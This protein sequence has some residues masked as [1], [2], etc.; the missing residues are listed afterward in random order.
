MSGFWQFANNDGSGITRI[1]KKQNPSLEELLDEKETVGQLLASNAKLIQYFRRPEILDKLVEYVVSGDNYRRNADTVAPD[2]NEKEDTQ[3]QSTSKSQKLKESSAEPKADNEDRNESDSD[4]SSDSSSSSLSS[5]SSSSD[6]DEDDDDNISSSN[7]ADEDDLNHTTI[8]EKSNNDKVCDDMD[9]GFMD[10]ASDELVD[11]DED[12]DENESE[13]ETPA[14][15]CM[16][17]AGVATDILSADVWS[18][19]DAFMENTIALNNLWSVL[20]RSDSL[21]ISMGNYFMKINEHLLDMKTAEMIGYIH[22]VPNLVK[23]FLHHI[24]TS[25]L[26]DFLLKLIATDRPESPTGIIELLH[27]QNLIPFLVSRLNSEC[28]SDVQ[29]AAADFLKA[30]ITISANNGDDT[31]IGPNEL[32]RQLVSEDVMQDF[33]KIMLQG[34]YALANGVGI[35]IEIIRKNNSD[36]DPIPVRYDANDPDPPTPRDPIYL[37]DMVKIFAENMSKFSVLLHKDINKPLLTPIGEIKP[38]GFERF[39][40]CELTAELIH[41]SNMALLNDREASE[42][43][44]SR[45]II[46]K[47]LTEKRKKLLQDSDDASSIPWDEIDISEEIANL[48]LYSPSDSDRRNDDDDDSKMN[49]DDDVGILK[50]VNADSYEDLNSEEATKSEKALRCNPVVGDLLKISLYDHKIVSSIVS[51]FYQFPWNNFLHNVVFDIVQQILNAS[52][53]IGYNKFLVIDIFDRCEITS[54]LLEAYERCIKN[55]EETGIRLGYMGHLALIAEEIVKFVS[56]NLDNTI[57]SSVIRGAV[58]NPRWKDFEDNVLSD[59]RSK[60]NAV[61]GN[62]GGEIDVISQDADSIEEDPL[63]RHDM[64]VITDEDISV[65][66]EAADIIDDE[67]RNEYPDGE[68]LA[69]YLGHDMQEKEYHGSSLQFTDYKHDALNVSN[70]DIIEGCEVEETTVKR[71]AVDNDSTEVQNLLK[72]ELGASVN[73]AATDD[74]LRDLN[75]SRESHKRKHILSSKEHSFRTSLQKPVIATKQTQC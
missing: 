18:L 17:R 42:I 3:S 25:P 47:K 41:C 35:V 69:T 37:G 11:E 51:M 75:V 55:E 6:S 58:E 71:G 2:A 33:V 53:H 63:D 21:S 62:E 40:I 72:R 10:T 19:T 28:S 32:T 23:G 61:L 48:H 16:R 8:P 27:D 70:S 49:I 22:K 38:L 4:D 26:M 5:N 34:G 24:D 64:K 66:S 15:R 7:K 56:M 59:I 45:D 44:K 12:E 74:T 36:Y 73:G 30:L 39:K 67:N 13:S 14:E 29:S 1:L 31:S 60:Y 46:R 52:L 57:T 65:G 54:M 68:N 9:W 43:V 20:D 50:A